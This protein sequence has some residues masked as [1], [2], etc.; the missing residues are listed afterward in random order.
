[1]KQTNA[2]FGI[3]GTIE[4]CP[5][6]VL[7]NSLQY[8]AAN[9][10]QSVRYHTWTSSLDELFD[11]VS[12]QLPS[13]LKLANVPGL[14]FHQSVDDLVSS[15]TALGLCDSLQL[16]MIVISLYR[17]HGPRRLVVCDVIR[18]YLLSTDG[19]TSDL[20]DTVASGD[21]H[22]FSDDQS[23]QDLRQ[24]PGAKRLQGHNWC[25]EH[26][27]IFQLL[28]AALTVAQDMNVSL[29]EAVTQWQKLKMKDGQTL[30]SFLS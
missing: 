12:K 9:D 29:E 10:F 8:G 27:F 19:E 14:G 11:Y 4:Q 24:S 20:L 2:R 3:G 6:R 13:L 16:C 26:V 23:L 15:M 28:L 22:H 18:K 30:T 21:T 17:E 1:L 7:L 25:R 5:V